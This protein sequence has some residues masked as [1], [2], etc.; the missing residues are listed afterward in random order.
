[1]PAHLKRPHVLVLAVLAFAVAGCTAVTGHGSRE[2]G[3][4]TTG[5][6]AAS[7]TSTAPTTTERPYM[8]VTPTLEITGEAAKPGTKVKFGEQA[9]LPVYSYYAKGQLGVTLTVETVKA[10]DEDVEG[11]PLKDEDKTKLRGKFFFFVKQTLVNVDGANLSELY[12]P[13]FTPTTRSGGWP[14]QLFGMGNTSVTGCEDVTSLPKDFTAK[15]A[16]FEACKLYFG[17]SSDPIASVAYTKA[18]YDTGATKA[19]TWKK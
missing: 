13:T 5:P 8:T 1:M 6:N 12:V 10:S 17:V 2:G 9:V 15:G 19:V 3:V 18:P 7:A 16:K 11:L 14:G 4:T